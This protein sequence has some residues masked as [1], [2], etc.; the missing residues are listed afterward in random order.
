MHS[1]HIRLL[2]ETRCFRHEKVL[3]GLTLQGNALGEERFKTLVLCM[4]MRDNPAIQVTS[5]ALAYLLSTFSFTFSTVSTQSNLSTL[6]TLSSPFLP[7][8]PLPSFV[9]PT[10]LLSLCL[11]LHCLCFNATGIILFFSIVSI[12]ELTDIKYCS[13]GCWL[14][15]DIYL[16]IIYLL[17]LACIQLVNVIISTPDDLDVRIHLRSEIMRTGMV[18][19]IKVSFFIICFCLFI[20]YYVL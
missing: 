11:C 14:Q 8:F 15:E 16:F 10:C 1:L 9:L 6:S 5:G 4:G 12:V 2:G 7:F 3:E 19:L 13:F 18:D 20:K 17:Q